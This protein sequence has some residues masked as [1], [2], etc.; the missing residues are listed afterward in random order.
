MANRP[1]QAGFISTRLR[2][3]RKQAGLTQEEFA[4]ASGINYKVYQSLEAGRRWNLR[5]RTILK[6]AEIHHLSVSQFFALTA[7]RSHFKLRSRGVAKKRD[8]K[9][10]DT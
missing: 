9:P 5:Y 10:A 7:P 4:E 1:A 8:K 6:L 2:V 3:L